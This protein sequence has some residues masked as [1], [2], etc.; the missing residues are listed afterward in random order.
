ML[1]YI[2]VLFAVAVRIFL[3][4]YLWGFTPLAASLLFFGSR[5]SRRQL[6]IPLT[7]MAVGDVVLTKFIYRYAFTPEHLVSWIW[8]AAILWLGTRLGRNPRPLPIV[9]AALAS[10]VSFF[11]VSNFSSWATWTD[12]YPRTLQGLM[13]AYAAGL[14]FFRRS[15]EGDLLFTMA[16]FATPVLLRILSDAFGKAVTNHATHS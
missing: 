10:S 12:M 2:F 16:M 9:G 13:A 8:Y 4:P 7:I 14:P 3:W 1:A 5:A 6:W 11:L 15:I